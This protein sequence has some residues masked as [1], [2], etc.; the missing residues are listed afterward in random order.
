MSISDLNIYG[1][2]YGYPWAH[3]YTSGCQG[4]ISAFIANSILCR[5]S[6][7]K[8]KSQGRSP[9]KE[10]FVYMTRCSDRVW[11]SSCKGCLSYFLLVG[12]NNTHKL[13][14]G[15]IYFI[16]Q[17]VQV[18]VHT[19]LTLRQRS[20]AK[21]HHRGKQCMAWQ[22]GRQRQTASPPSPL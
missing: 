11:A 9:G 18:S 1:K 16:S 20:M 12:Q 17:F 22:A 3:N 13:K 5:T 8:T 19:S 6:N 2:K 7:S 21:R 14:R 15:K 10:Q 4:L